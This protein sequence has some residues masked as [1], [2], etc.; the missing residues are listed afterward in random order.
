M[1]KEPSG[2]HFRIKL[3]AKE[4]E[5]VPRLLDVYTFLHDFNLLYEISRAAT[6]PNYDEFEFSRLVF[7]RVD[8]LFAWLSDEDRLRTEKLSKESPLELVTVLAAAPV[9]VGAL[10]GV[11][12]I[13]EKVINL[14]LN[15]KK[16]KEEVAKLERDR[17]KE[18]MPSPVDDPENSLFLYQN[19]KLLERRLQSRGATPYYEAVGERLKSAKIRIVELE[20]E[21]RSPTQ[22]GPPV[23][24]VSR[25]IRTIKPIKN[26]DE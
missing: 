1:E 5:R 9:A 10:W 24:A 4:D 26:A 6:D 7:D 17:L 19:P 20:I 25:R 16:L 13:L 12:Q 15:R 2:P 22:E 14:P 8:G 21:L 23:P 18:E 11:V 3:R